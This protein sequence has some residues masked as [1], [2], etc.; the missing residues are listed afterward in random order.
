MPGEHLY[1]S[2]GV[3]GTVVRALGVAIVSGRYP[4]GTTLPTEDQLVAELG[5]SRSA[6]REGIRVLAGK[7]LVEPQTRRGTIV[8]P[9]DRWH[10]LDPDILVWRYESTT[11]AADFDDLTGLRMVLEPSAARMAAERSTPALI[12]PIEAALEEMRRTVDDTESFIEADLA[13]HS[14]IVAAT[15]NNLLVHLNNMMGIALSAHRH[16]HTRSR[17]RHRKTIGEHRRILDAIR[18]HDPDQAELA[19]RELVERA[20]QDVLYY[21]GRARRSGAFTRRKDSDPGA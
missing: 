14:G 1:P 4:P 6:L 3:H 10:L 2:R 13:F 7:G 5:V 17:T 18:D 20:H 8:R 21:T 16:V 19:M 9:P 15:D 11:S 12:K